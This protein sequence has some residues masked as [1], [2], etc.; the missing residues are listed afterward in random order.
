MN[1]LRHVVPVLLFA[2]INS[3]AFATEMFGTDYTSCGDRPSTVETVECIDTK[4]KVWDQ[5]LNAA[6]TM[7]QHTVEPDQREPLRKAQRL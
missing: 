5:R 6:Y 1:L 4:T 2:C 7:L 3:P